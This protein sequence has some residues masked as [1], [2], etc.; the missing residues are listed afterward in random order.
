MPRVF[1]DACVVIYYVERQ[2][3]IYPV[4]RAALQPPEGQPV[5]VGLSAQAEPV[6]DITQTTRFS[7]PTGLAAACAR[8]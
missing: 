7:Q 6:R 5:W 1:L 8:P 4:V 3:Q 2:A